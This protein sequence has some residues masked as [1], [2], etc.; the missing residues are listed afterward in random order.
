MWPRLLIRRVSS[1]RTLCCT[2]ILMVVVAQIAPNAKQ[3]T[4]SLLV[5]SMIPIRL[6]L[7]VKLSILFVDTLP[8]PATALAF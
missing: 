6:D 1:P 3:L 8:C 5:A 4:S 7:P 2:L